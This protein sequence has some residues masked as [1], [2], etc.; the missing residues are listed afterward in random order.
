MKFYCYLALLVLLQGCAASNY[1]YDTVILNG[2]MMDPETAFDSTANVGIR[3]GRI[4]VITQSAI[5][6]DEVIE[7]AGLVV[8]PGFIDTHTHGSDKFTIK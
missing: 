8:A 6:G 7:A 3:D 1:R 2:R 5:K 4:S